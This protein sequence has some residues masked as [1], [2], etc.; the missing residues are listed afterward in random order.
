M[1]IFAIPI[2][3]YHTKNNLVKNKIQKNKN[4]N[5]TNYLSTQ[6]FTISSLPSFKQNNCSD[7]TTKSITKSELISEGFATTEIKNNKIIN[8]GRYIILS[9][10]EDLIAL[11]N[12]PSAW[13]KEFVMIQDIDFESENFKGIGG[14]QKS[15]SGIFNGNGYKIK[16]L[17]I[18]LPTN[19]NIGLFK[20]CNNAEIKNLVLENI[21]I[22]GKNYIGGVIGFAENT[23]I[24]NVHLNGNIAGEYCV[25]GLVGNLIHS[26]IIDSEFSGKVCPT[27]NFYKEDEDNDF[28]ASSYET[29]TMFSFGGIVGTAI[30]SKITSTQIEAQ[31]SGESSIGGFAGN[32][33]ESQ[34]QD[35]Y[36]SATVNGN[37]DLGLIAGQARNTIVK[38]TFFDKKLPICDSPEDI[39]L[40]N[41]YFREGALDS[42]AFKDWN[43]EIWNIAN[44]KTPRLKSSIRLA[45]PVRIFLEDL[46]N[47]IRDKN[48]KLTS[49]TYVPPKT[50]D[51][52]LEDLE[53]PV[54]YSENEPILQEIEN[55][56]SSEKLAEIFAHYVNNMRYNFDA[57]DKKNDE[58]LLA[59]VKKP[60]F[61]LSKRYSREDYNAGYSIYCT[62]LYV[63]SQ[64]NKGYV[65]REALKREDIDPYV[66]NGFW[67]NV[68]MAETLFKF[69]ITTNLFLLFESK[70]PIIKKYMKEKLPL[71][72]GY[73]V[74]DNVLEYLYNNPSENI[75]YD[76][77]KRV[78]KVPTE[79]VTKG[80]SFKP[81]A[82]HIEGKITIS[83]LLEA[84]LHPDISEN[85]QDSQG[86]TIAHL[87]PELS[88]TE[89]I[90]LSNL[91]I[92]KCGNLDIKNNSGK[93]ALDLAMERRQ[94][95][96]ITQLANKRP[97]GFFTLDED[98]NNLAILNAKFNKGSKAAYLAKILHD[99]GIIMNHQNSE[100]STQ[101]HEAIKNN[102]ITLINY[103]LTS[104]CSVDN[105]DDNGQTPLHL[106]FMEKDSKTIKWLLDNFAYPSFRDKLNMRPKDYW[107]EYEKTLLP[108]GIDID[109]IEKEYEISI[110]IVENILNKFNTDPIAIPEGRLDVEDYYFY[111]YVKKAND[112]PQ[113]AYLNFTYAMKNY[114]NHSQKLLETLIDMN[115]PHT[116]EM[117]NFIFKENIQDINQKNKDNQTLL[118]YSLIKYNET[119]NNIEKLNLMKIIKF[120]ID[121]GAD[122]DIPDANGQTGLHHCIFTK[123]CILFNELLGKH[124][125]INAPDILGN[126]PIFYLGENLKNPMR[127][128]FDIYAKKRNIIPKIPIK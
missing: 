116:M 93:T 17:N 46:N 101:L 16:N 37:K 56:H 29:K 87:L 11:A 6:N 75:E 20:T 74:E 92:K 43:K 108:L 2:Y 14:I 39:E 67:D 61:K 86:N 66:L 106:A 83:T 100:F 32:I 97:T 98:G 10:K 22:K 24:K 104:G 115:S 50:I 110:G 95:A 19:S 9:N 65:F 4:I 42:S 96:I 84:M 85:Y 117:L 77:E 94:L 109:A 91:F 82:M 55:S 99:N 123:N 47:D 105:C 34:I 121:N 68:D 27:Q 70:N 113:E 38:N 128:V 125:N 78:I 41:C 124:P 71:S 3:S 30:L 90:V 103:L 114:P 122:I 25:G 33:A 64:L 118:I 21:N 51:I 59:L 126:S 120:L 36:C 44:T 89:Q 76:N 102:N 62:P 69:P 60:E 18:N 28:F 26:S 35:C 81:E 57:N 13:N 107:P 8:R 112:N 119:D 45:S 127:I 23:S 5:T 40:I 31:I 54:H 1:K 72:K 7:N 49:I 53:P 15:F 52:P 80:S 111:Q 12:T 48:I 79:I 58:V 63:L 73:K 88:E